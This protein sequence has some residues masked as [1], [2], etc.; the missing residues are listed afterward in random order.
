[1]GS[2]T[3]TNIE[4]LDAL[5]YQLDRTNVFHSWSAQASLNPL[6]LAGASGCEVWDHSGKRY[7]DFSSQLINTNIGHT[8][9]KVVAAI[10][11]QADILPTVA[12]AHANLARGRAAELILK[13]ANAFSSS[14]ARSFDKV[15]FTNGGADANENAIRMARLTTGRDT[16]LS[17][18]RSY[19]GSTGSAIVAT[20][21]FRR[22]ENQY[23]RGHTHFFGPFPYRSEFWSS[24]PEEETERALHHLR[25]V[26]ECEGPASIA[27]II[28]ETIPGTAGVIVPPSGWLAGVRRLCDEFGAVLICDEVMAGFGRTGDWFAWQNQEVNPERVRPDLISF[29]KGVNGGYVPAGGVILSEAISR[30]F[31]QRFYPGG[32]TY[33][34]HPLAMAAIVATLEAYEEDRILE[35]ATDI[36]RDVLGPGLRKLGEKHRIVGEVRGLGVFWAL[37]LVSDPATKKPVAPSVVGKVKNE[38]VKRGLL[39]FVV[40]NRLHV[41]PPCVVTKDEV[42]RALGI[43]DEVLTAVEA[44][45][46]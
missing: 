39:P 5:T 17:A 10:K 12:P 13:H 35:H 4:D 38:C 7:L 1:M 34:G 41:T 24:S 28:L 21:D 32:L 16:V 9:P 2:V 31:D 20:G 27:A 11:K 8:H 29:A 19:H 37:D 46:L 18:Y 44:E 43:Y 42:E 6:T 26:I 15:F 40:D 30:A 3:P 14:G 23:A 25:R 36:G 33:S 22:V 45:L